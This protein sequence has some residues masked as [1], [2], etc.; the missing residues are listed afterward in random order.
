[1]VHSFTLGLGLMQNRLYTVDTDSNTALCAQYT[2]QVLYWSSSNLQSTLLQLCKIN[3]LLSISVC[4]PEKCLYISCQH[5]FSEFLYSLI[6]T[7]DSI[8]NKH[9][10]VFSCCLN[11]AFIISTDVLFINYNRILA[12]IMN[13][14]T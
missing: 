11:Y 7:T 2:L 4:A 6:I 12:V 8:L 10:Q 1:M 5:Y 13:L 9:F 3:T 14:Y